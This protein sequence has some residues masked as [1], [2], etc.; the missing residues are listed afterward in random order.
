MLETVITEATSEWRKVD[1]WYSS[2]APEWLKRVLRRVTPDHI[3]TEQLIGGDGRGPASPGVSNAWT[4]PIKGRI[5]M[6]TT[7][8]RT[9]VGIK[10]SGADLAEIERIGAPIEALF[11]PSRER[12]TCSRNGPAE[13]TS[14]TSSGSGTSWRAMA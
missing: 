12:E 5:D 6:L 1:T 4:M 2:W 7:G 3:S 10:I 13:V 8:V 9:P 14:L 11:P